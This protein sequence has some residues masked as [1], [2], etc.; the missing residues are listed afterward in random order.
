LNNQ[1]STEE[2]TLPQDIS[3]VDLIE[4]ETTEV[5]TSSS[6]LWLRGWYRLASPSIPASNATL[7][8]RE[9]YRRGRMIAVMLLVML[10]VFVVVMLT[11]GVFVNRALFPN[12]VIIICITIIAA[13]LNRRGFVIIAGV[14]LVTAIDASLIADLYSYKG[15]LDVFLLPLLDLLVIPELLAVSLLPTNWVFV[16]ATVHIVFIIAAETFLMPHTAAMQQ[17]LNS[18]SLADA[19]VRPIVLQIA[20][21]L[22][23]YLWVRRA[24]RASERADRATVIATL[25]RTLSEQTQVETEQKRRLDESIQQIID[26]HQRVANGD[27]NARVPLSDNNSLWSIAGSLNNLLARL[28]RTNQEARLLQRTNDAVALFLQAST[29]ANGG[30]IKWQPTETA[31]DAIVQQHNG[32]IQTKQRGHQN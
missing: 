8:Q 15:G 21:A 29:Q 16:S 32:L 19:L 7:A 5:H 13:F 31:I 3:V 10:A 11:V 30:L 14:M 24:T 12:M 23:T 26:V 25:E 9:S 18:P 4:Q 17:Y 2:D 1:F 20:V 22:V 28:Q 27:F 6:N